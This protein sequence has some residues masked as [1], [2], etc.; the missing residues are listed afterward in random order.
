MVEN[1]T[2]K[3]Y[4]FYKII[5]YELGLKARQ[6]LVIFIAFLIKLDKITTLQIITM[7]E[8]QP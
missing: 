1:K 3:S 7:I 4:Y 6:V 8:K 2:A 5:L